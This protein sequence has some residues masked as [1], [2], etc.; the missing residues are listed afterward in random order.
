MERQHSL[1]ML[2]DI[3]GL[4]SASFDLVCHRDLRRFG[5]IVVAPSQEPNWIFAEGGARIRDATRSGGFGWTKR[6]HPSKQPFS[7]RL[8]KQNC[9]QRSKA[10]PGVVSDQLPYK[11][12]PGGHANKESFQFHVQH[13]QLLRLSSRNQVVGQLPASA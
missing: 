11:K 1:L 13:C 4:C 5:C 2:E 7:N 8:Q 10:C 9:W 3:Y 12:G 6:F